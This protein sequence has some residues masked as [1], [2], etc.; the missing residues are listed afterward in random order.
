ML[1]FRLNISKRNAQV[2]SYN[3]F[4]VNLQFS[5]H[6]KKDVKT[7]F[8]NRESTMHLTELALFYYR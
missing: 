6:P 3:L 5:L 4:T 2:S 7:L 1:L 8:W